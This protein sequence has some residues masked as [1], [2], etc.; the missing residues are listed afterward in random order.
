MV[1]WVKPGIV[2]TEIEYTAHIDNR[3]LIE[4]IFIEFGDI[5]VEFVS[6]DRVCF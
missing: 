2:R 6:H 3:F 4:V 1:N 5:F